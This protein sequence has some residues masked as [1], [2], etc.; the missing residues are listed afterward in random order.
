MGGVKTRNIVNAVACIAV[1]VLGIIS[2]ATPWYFTQLEGFG[3]TARTECHLD[4]KC[5]GETVGDD[6]K[7]FYDA[8]LAFMLIGLGITLGLTGLVLFKVF[9]NSSPG[10]G[11]LRV[12]LGLGAFIAF[13]LAVIIFAGGLTSKNG[14]RKFWVSETALGITVT[15]GASVGWYFALITEVACII[16]TV[17]VK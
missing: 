7:P 8:A 11:K 15:A 1:L 13:L 2:V 3:S 5:G 14:D 16:A 17:L 10:G 4:A 9:K 12:A 6:V